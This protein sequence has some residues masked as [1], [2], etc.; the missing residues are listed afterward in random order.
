MR[1]L[2]KTIKIFFTRLFSN[3]I[4]RVIVS[5][6][7]WSEQEQKPVTIVFFLLGYLIYWDLLYLLLFLEKAEFFRMSF[8]S[9]FLKHETFHLPLSFNPSSLFA[10]NF[11]L[12]FLKTVTTFFFFSRHI[13][14]PFSVAILNPLKPSVIV[15]NLQIF[16]HFLWSA[17]SLRWWQIMV[18]EY[19]KNNCSF[20]F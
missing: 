9:D 14:V 19:W 10:F 6:Y 7:S 17:N 8:S 20:A 5:L 2:F 3:K 4:N 18:S 13:L 12:S 11:F 1:L 15:D 16:F